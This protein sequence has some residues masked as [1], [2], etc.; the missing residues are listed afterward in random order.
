M[1]ESFIT[2]N[3]INI[4]VTSNISF[5]IALVSLFISSNFNTK[6]P[7]L[8]KS[9]IDN[10]IISNK[11]YLLC[12]SQSFYT[13]INIQNVCPSQPTASQLSLQ[14]QRPDSQTTLP[15][16]QK[17]LPLLLICSQQPLHCE[18]LLMTEFGF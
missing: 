3:T 13:L 1:F 11:P 10:N 15:Q 16:P 14:S 8:V 17:K 9:Y 6:Y 7:L 5:F 4:F 18:L 12:I 2:I